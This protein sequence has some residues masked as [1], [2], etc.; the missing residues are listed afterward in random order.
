M[1]IY[2]ASSITLGSLAKGRV[3]KRFAEEL[4]HVLKDIVDEEK[5]SG[6]AREIHVVVKIAAINSD[7]EKAN[8][9]IDVF[10]KL[11]KK[12]VIRAKM[13]IE[14]SRGK[15]SLHEPEE[16]VQPEM[17]SGPMAQANA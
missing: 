15:V 8:C 2:S 1:E 11:P 6:K 4:A 17:F 9:S 13:D 5:D 3:E 16:E 12:G 14:K 7:R 10:S